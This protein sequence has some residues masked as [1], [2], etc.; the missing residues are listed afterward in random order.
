[1]MV[2]KIDPASNLATLARINPGAAANYAAAILH[3]LDEIVKRS[4]VGDP[5][6]S[7]EELYAQ[8]HALKNAVAPTGDHV[9]INA[10]AS[11]LGPLMQ[12]ERRT[13]MATQ[14]RFVASAAAMAVADYRRDVEA[15]ASSAAVNLSKP[16]GL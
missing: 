9:L 6:T 16:S 10:C 15:M 7:A 5:T 3:E 2:A 4:T 1:M 8:V 12:A 14:F 13:E 11:L